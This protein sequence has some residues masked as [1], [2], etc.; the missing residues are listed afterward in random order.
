MGE[1]SKHT[2][3]ALESNV[4]RYEQV[5]VPLHVMSRLS[6]EDEELCIHPRVYISIVFSSRLCKNEE[7]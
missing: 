2:I 5:C 7:V 3:L 6:K 1:I 4:V